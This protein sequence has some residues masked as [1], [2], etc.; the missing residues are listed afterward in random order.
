MG[1]MS[2]SRPLNVVI[3]GGGAAAAEVALV[4]R[5]QLTANVRLTFVAPEPDDPRLGA[6]H[7][8][9]PL[10][11]PFAPV[12]RRP[13]PTAALAHG[14]GAD[15][16][17]GRVLEVDGDRH[18]VHLDDGWTLGYDALVLAVGARP[19]PVVDADY[20][21]YGH[22]GPIAL[23]RIL[24][25]SGVGD[26]FPGLDFVIPP[27]VTRALSIYELAVLAGAEAHDRNAD[28]GLRLFTAEA[29]PL[30]AF[31]PAAQATT[32]RLLEA[33]GVRF[34]GSS[35]VHGGWG[36]RPLIALPVLDGPALAGVP[37]TDDGFIPIDGHGF[38]PGMDDVFAAGDAT[39]CPVK[40]VDVACAQAATIADVLAAC[41]GAA[42]T[43]VPW[44]PNV[45]EHLLGDFGVGML[46]PVAAAIVDAYQAIEAA[47]RSLGVASGIKDG[48]GA[49]L[50]GRLSGYGLVDHQTDDVLAD[51][52]ALRHMVERP[53]WS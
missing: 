38:V 11:D 36:D 44:L 9:A 53:L 43:P 51:L 18:Q 13:C 25:E 8:S 33:F 20:T 15:L 7:A 12:P 42:V 17:G 28:A 35:S 19:R 34:A 49:V 37:A 29:A 31:G 10:S 26:G 50:P 16:H 3:V 4:L 1:N 39:A 14:L 41:A 2:L 24:A 22:A 6:T 52:A 30:E 5:E 40:H 48:R 21:L 45:R 32:G 47:A 23:D 46:S 27:G